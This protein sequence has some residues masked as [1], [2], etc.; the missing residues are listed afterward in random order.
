MTEVTPQTPTPE[1]EPAVLFKNLKENTKIIETESL[2]KQLAVIEQQIVLAKEAGQ[3]NFTDRLAVAHDIIVREQQ[4]LIKGYKD[5]V[6][7]ADV[8]TLLSKTKKIK[9]I[10]LDRYPRAI[11]LEVLEKYKAAKNTELFDRFVI[12]FTDLTDQEYKSEEEKQ[13]VARNRDPV[14]FGCFQHKVTAFK[15]DRFYLI[16]DWEDE[17]CDLTF[18]KMIQAINEHFFI[19]S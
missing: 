18:N 9:I 14:L 13:Y 19:K 17:Y 1:A 7:E 4:L 6:Y 2:N 10:E 16:A 8:E 12:V 3:K 11:P 5:F 15:H